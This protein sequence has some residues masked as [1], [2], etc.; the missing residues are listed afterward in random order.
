[1]ASK[2]DLGFRVRGFLGQRWDSSN[3]YQKDL[4][5]VPRRTWTEV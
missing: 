5:S 1:M 2:S 3:F 4:F